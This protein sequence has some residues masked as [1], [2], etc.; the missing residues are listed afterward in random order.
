MIMQTEHFRVLNVKCGGCAANIQTSLA[1]LAGVD[2]VEVTIESGEVTVQ[3]TGLD[4]AA[5]SRKLAD[6]GYPEA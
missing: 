4:R 6:A 5:L 3:G 1:E 2:K